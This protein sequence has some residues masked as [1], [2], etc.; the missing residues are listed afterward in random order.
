MIIIYAVIILISFVFLF[1][2]RFGVQTAYHKC[3]KDGFETVPNV[4]VVI[5]EDDL[6]HLPEPVKRYLDYVGIVGSEHLTHFKVEFDGQMCLD[7]ERDWSPVSGEQH[8]FINDGIRL[9]LMSM[10]YK[11]LI[12][13]GLH[14]FNQDQAS[15]VIKILDIIKVVDNRGEIMKKSETVTYFNDLC[16]F[17]PGS[18]IDKRILW[19]DIDKKTV[20]ASMTLRGVT[21]SAILH[22]DDSGRLINF[23]SNDRYAIEPD[24]SYKKKPWS[25]PLY[26]YKKINGL[27]L[28]VTGEAIWHYDDGDFSYLK[29]NIKNVIV[30]P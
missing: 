18:L 7:K 20:K 3:V 26:E 28:P 22:F 27:N 16:I 12:I 11:S 30:N 6:S 13:N 9:F 4:K 21:V 8:T 15:M 29:L 17:A 19:E 23:V 25:T 5:G 14:H 10:K 2:W 1:R 24:G